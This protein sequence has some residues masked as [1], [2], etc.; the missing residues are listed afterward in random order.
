MLY[1]SENLGSE[2]SNSIN[3]PF[4][5]HLPYVRLCAELFAC[6]VTHGGDIITENYYLEKFNRK[7]GFG[8]P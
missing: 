1:P 6:L 3:P 5:G 2:P 4:I 8:S 7:G